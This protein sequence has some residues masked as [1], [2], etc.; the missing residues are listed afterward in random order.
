MLKRVGS[1]LDEELCGLFPHRQSTEIRLDGY[2]NYLS[3]RTHRISVCWGGAGRHRE[4]ATLVIRGAAVFF[5]NETQK[6]LILREFRPMHSR[7]SVVT[8]M[9]LVGRVET[10]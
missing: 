4:L 10:R 5:D 6:C 8:A 9:P 7:F 1:T 3:S 2:D